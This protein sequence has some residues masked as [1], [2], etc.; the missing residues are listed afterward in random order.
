M[1][2][3]RA[4]VL[5][6]GSLVVAL[7]GCG[8]VEDGRTEPLQAAVTSAATTTLQ[9][10]CGGPAVS[11]FHADLGFKGG[12]TLKTG[13]AVNT[14]GV[15][16]PA[17]MAVYQTAR[18]GTFS[19][20]LVGFAASSPHQLRL[21]FAEIKVG[22]AGSRLFNVSINGAVVLTGFDVF[23]TA[24]GRDIAVVEAFTASANAS[25]EIDLTFTSVRDKAL[26][27]GIEVLSGAPNGSACTSAA[28]C[29]SG[30]CVDGVCCN[31]AACGSCMACNLA[32][33]P[34]TCAVVPA[35]LPDPRGVCVDQGAASCR[36]DGRCDGA[37]SCQLYAAGTV[38][39]APSCPVGSPALTTQGTCSAGACVAALTN[40]VPYL[41]NAT[42]ACGT[43]CAGDADC[44]AGFHCDLATALCR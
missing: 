7:A 1:N 28:Q 11:P 39:S 44:A 31:T 6:V 14:S 33:A 17:P 8:A 42:N 32:S 24:G 12:S 26:V 19:Y 3:I 30:N 34:G 37:G 15:T 5:M 40:C 25:G 38:C 29:A 16:N 41:C 13:A 36:T 22:A 4:R 21:H 20:K 27:S 2:Q 43:S 35:G 10:N 18:V 9:I 23:K